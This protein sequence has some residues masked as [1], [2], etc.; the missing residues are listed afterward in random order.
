MFA[1]PGWLL[2]GLAACAACLAS[3]WLAARRRAVATARMGRL[4]TLSRLLPAELAPRRR[5]KSWLSC[6]G[7]ALLF[8]ALA[9]PQWGVELVPTE[10]SGREVV[11]AVDLSLSMLAEDVK[12]SRIERAKQELALLLDQLK[13]ERVGVLAFAGDA[14]M[15]CPM[16]TDVDAA[17]QVLRALEPGAVPVPGTAI[18]TAI[19]TATQALARYDGEKSLV[20]I[21]D[22]ED[23]K[24]D[25]AGAAEQAA[26]EGIRIYAIGIGTPEGE[27]IPLKDSAGGL[28]GYKKDKRGETVVTR[29][30]DAMLSQIAQKTGGAYYRAS[31]GQD[32][33]GEIVGKIERG[34]KGDA[35][36]G[37]A[38][39]YKNR[40]TVPLTLSFLLLLL[41]FLIP[42]RSAAG[43]A[44][45]AE[46]RLSS[47]KVAATLLLVLLAVPRTFA[48]NAESALRKGNQLYDREQYEPALEQYAAAGQRDHKDARPVFNAGDALYRL[49]RFDEASEAF[50]TLSDAKIPRAARAAAAYNLGDARYQAGDAAGAVA[51]FRKAVVLDPNDEAARRNL[52]VALKS[53]KSPPKR[54]KNGKNKKDR[55]D[56]DKDKKQSQ[57]NA[58]KGRPPEPKTRPQDQLSKEDAQRVMRAVAE[59]E[60]AAAKQLQLQKQDAKRTAPEEDW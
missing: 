2:W 19:R 17:K 22:G 20:L 16:T 35:V 4:A 9:G 60:K 41:E 50:K 51:A 3:S 15:M 5:L 33:V 43:R 28:S 46:G 13:G 7:L 8:L 31:V 6:A 30:G 1:E 34:G 11:V 56:A 21:T 52:A 48:A 47:P 14:F 38:T 40:F 45:P 55:D 39:H 44:Q 29:L 37:T 53:L 26:G 23:H 57:Q 27:P 18:G 25:P 59:K 32:E 10:S 58:D 49:E 36:S 24:T 12:P 54:D 42:E